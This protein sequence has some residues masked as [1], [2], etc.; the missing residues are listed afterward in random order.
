MTNGVQTLVLYN[1]DTFGNVGASQTIDF[2]IARPSEPFPVVPVAAV[3]V[4]VAVV[5][6][7]G[8]LVYHKKHKL[9]MVQIN[10]WSISKDPKN[11]QYT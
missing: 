3:S 6:V 5:V 2:T 11:Y 7:V 10:S 8:L 9:N 1:N 4:A